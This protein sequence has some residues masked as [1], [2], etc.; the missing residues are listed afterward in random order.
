MNELKP[1]NP[2]SLQKI[3]CSRF[4]GIVS[5]Q[6]SECNLQN[7]WLLFKNAGGHNSQDPP[8]EFKRLD[9]TL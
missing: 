6:F 4:A 5:K 9:L 8:S 7:D 2:G 3:P 1:P